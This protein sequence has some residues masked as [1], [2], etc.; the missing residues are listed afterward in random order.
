VGE[1]N[2]SEDLASEVRRDIRK[3]SDWDLVENQETTFTGVITVSDEKYQREDD[4]KEQVTEKIKK[5]LIN[6]NANKRNVRVYCTMM[7]EDTWGA[8]DFEVF[9]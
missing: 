1:T 6:R 3:I 4:A 8:F 9:V 7:L 5:I 2:R